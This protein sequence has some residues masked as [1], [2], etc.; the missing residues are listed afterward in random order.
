MGPQRGWGRGGALPSIASQ[1]CEAGLASQGRVEL[2]LRKRLRSQSL[3]TLICLAFLTAPEK[4]GWACWQLVALRF[5]LLKGDNW[6]CL[7][8]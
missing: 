7:Q 5:R 3:T 8:V 6:T 2:S 4:G 1:S